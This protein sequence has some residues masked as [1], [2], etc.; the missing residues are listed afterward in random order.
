[1]R[2][3]RRGIQC[4]SERGERGAVFAIL[5]ASLLALFGIA[6]LVIDVGQILLCRQKLY[7]ALDAAVLAGAQDLPNSTVA[8]ATVDEYIAMNLPE[9]ESVSDPLVTLDFSGSPVGRIDAQAQQVVYLSFMRIFGIQS[10]TIFAESSA[11]KTSVDLMLVIDR[12]GSMCEDYPGNPSN[13]PPVGPWEP[14]DSVKDAAVYFA[15]ELG[16][17]TLM[18]VVSYCTVPTC[19]VPLKFLED[20]LDE[21]I[22]GIQSLAPGRGAMCYTDIGGGIH[23]AVDSLLSSGRPNPKAIVLI[24]D[25]RPN[26]IQGVNYG[27]TE[28]P[29]RYTRQAATRADNNGIVI[30]AIGFGDEADITLMQNVANITGGLFYY[31]PDS[32]DLYAVFYEIANKAFVRRVRYESES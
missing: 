11:E 10:T 6:A 19:N 30:F 7:N 22:N 15:S 12:S 18:G 17:Q 13:C 2:K 21:V 9:N 5:A 25:G 26:I 3:N 1:M 4:R 27:Y 24:T 8:S 14:M 20:E 32:D 29:R 28:P 16:P 31:A 23:V